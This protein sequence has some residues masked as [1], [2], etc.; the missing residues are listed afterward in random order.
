MISLRKLTD[1]DL[2]EIHQWP[3]YA[4]DMQQM[5]YALREQGWLEELRPQPANA[6]FAAIAG[7]ELIGFSILARTAATEA[8]FRIARTN[9]PHRIGRT[10]AALNGGQID[11]LIGEVALFFTDK[12]HRVITTHDV[13]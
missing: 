3:P 10:S 11:A 1:A 2:T 9:D 8:E 4:G 6:I 13:V 5:D 12:E 7:D